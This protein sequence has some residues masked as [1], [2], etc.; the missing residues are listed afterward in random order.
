MT[1]P[2]IDPT[3]GVPPEIHAAEEALRRVRQIEIVLVSVTCLA[4]VAAL[5]YSFVNSN[6]TRLLADTIADCTTKGG[7]CYEDNRRSSLE[8]R[9]DLKKL[10][11]DVGQCQTLQL[12]LHRDA[13]ERAHAVNAEHHAYVYAA[14]TNETP[15]PIPEELKAACDQFIPKAQGGTR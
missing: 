3:N 14:P 12:L 6:R 13:N 4:A 10:I 8:F 7:Q 11:S 5:A 2:L 9:E 15:P 1:E